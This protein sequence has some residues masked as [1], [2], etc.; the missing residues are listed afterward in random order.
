VKKINMGKNLHNQYHQTIPKGLPSGS[1]LIGGAGWGGLAEQDKT[2][3][4]DFAL[5]DAKSKSKRED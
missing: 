2:G 5:T 1:K 3:R 4:R